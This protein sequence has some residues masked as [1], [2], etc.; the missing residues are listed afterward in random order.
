MNEKE[1]YDALEKPQKNGELFWQKLLQSQNCANEKEL[2]QKGT[3]LAYN[4]YFVNA[5]KNAAD[6]AERAR[7]E[8]VKNIQ[9][10]IAELL[11]K[12][13][14]AKEPEE[15]R[16]TKVPN[17]REELNIAESKAQESLAELEKIE[18]AI[19]EQIVDCGIV[20]GEY[21]STLEN[22]QLSIDTVGDKSRDDITEEEKTLWESQL[23]LLQTNNCAELKKI[24]KLKT[25][26][27]KFKEFID[28]TE[29]HKSA[30]RL[31]V[32]CAISEIASTK[33]NIE[34]F[35]N[36]FENMTTRFMQAKNDV[37]GGN[38]AGAITL[39]S[40][41]RFDEIVTT[42]LNNTLTEGN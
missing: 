3:A 14:A 19:Q 39:L 4:P 5:V 36:S 18:R 27:P 34:S 10:K 38:Y 29:K 24:Q 17:F 35:V 13:L 12:E 42:Q 9:E 28:L 20:A 1:F 2:F 40:Q 25:E 32:S 22:I 8:N 41:E 15:K 23:E 21:L 6:E 26:N 11:L 7:Y 31:K 30:V 37:R 33:R 16:L